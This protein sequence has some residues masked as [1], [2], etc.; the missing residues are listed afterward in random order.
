MPVFG[1][2]TIEQRVNEALARPQFY[3]TAVSFLAGFAVVL[4]TMGIYGTV[5]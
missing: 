4:A 3:G 1:V 5:S 2:T